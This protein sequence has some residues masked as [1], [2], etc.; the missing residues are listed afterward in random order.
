MKKSAILILS[1][2]L[3][4]PAAI[5]TP[6]GTASAAIG[7]AVIATDEINVRSGPGLSHEI[8]SVV[9]RNE[10]YPILEEKGDWVQIQLNN[11]QKGWVVDWLIQK[12]AQSSGGSES[13]SG[14]VTSSASDLRIRKG[15]G[16]S[17]EVQGTFPQGEQADVLKIDGKWMKISYQN[18]T[19]WVHSDYVT[20]DGSEQ[21]TAQ[22]SGTNTS[23]KTG[24]VGVSILNVR[25]DASHQGTIIAT[26]K[27]N[28]DVTII[29]EQHGWYEIEF[30]GQKGWAASHYI[31]EDHKENTGDGETSAASDAKQKATI[32]YEGTNIRSDASTSSPI[33]ERAEKG[34]SYPIT[35]EKADWY[36]ITLSNGNTAYVASWVVQTSDGSSSAG[37]LDIPSPPSSKRS[38]SNGSIQ[39]KT[40]VIDAGHG[41]HDSGTIGTRG[42]LEKRLTIKTANLLAAKLKADGVNVY[43]TRNDDT[44]VSLQSRVATS[45]Y[46]NADAFISIHYD[47]IAN[48]SVNG[49]TA[50]YYSTSKDQKLAADVQSEIEKHSPLKSRGVLFGDYFV[51]RENQ[52]PAALLELGYLSNPQEEAVVSTN[53][54]R[55]RVTDGIRSGLEHYF[56]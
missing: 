14:K 9:S 51:L 19:G 8:I 16:T 28:T 23:S 13:T 33:V 45:H 47:S 29:D 6:S 50:Y 48:S 32:V 20:Q 52:Q 40:V 1:I 36:E 26:L 39:N 37:D 53:A 55:E 12:K 7:E 22:S 25:S 46:R 18:I 4:A 3:A 31:V 17:Y 24:T 42:T 5:F 56:D 10:S 49:N 44:F 38:D 34:E 15:P 11:G 54:Y 2:M 21:K 41:G 27:R 35:G 43:M 30:D